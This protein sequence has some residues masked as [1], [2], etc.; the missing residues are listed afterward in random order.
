VLGS[1]IQIGS[2]NTLT[3]SVAIDLLD[4][5][6]LT[7]GTDGDIAIVERSAVLNANTSL[8]SVLIG[9]PVAQAL[10][11]DSLIISNVTA[12][13]DMAFYGNLGGHSQQFLFY[14]TSAST[15][16]L[17][18]GS[19][20]Q[21]SLALTG[22]SFD[23]TAFTNTAAANVFRTQVK[24]TNAVTLTTGTVPI[25]ATLALAEPNI[26]IG[27]GAA[28]IAA[29]FYIADAPTEGS[30]NY[31]SYTASGITFFAG[32]IQNVVTPAVTAAG[33]TLN[34][35]PTAT[36]LTAA[37]GAAFTATGKR[38]VL[39]AITP[40]ANGSGITMTGIS[41]S[42]GAIANVV[43]SETITIT[44]LNITGAAGAA[45][46]TGV[47]T[48]K[49][50]NITNPNQAANSATNA[51][52]GLNITGGAVAGSGSAYQ[53]G[54]VI[55]MAASS[56][57]GLLVTTGQSSFS[58]GVRTIL[59]TSATTANN[60]NVNAVVAGGGLTA[61][62]GKSFT[63]IV[64]YIYLPAITPVANGA[65]ITLTGL[66]M[67]AG[68]ISSVADSENITVKQIIIT[69]GAGGAAETGIYAFTG[70]DIT[71]PAQAANA[72]VNAG[73]GVKITGGATAGA[74]TAYQRGIDITMAA[75]T[76][77]AM[78][79]VSGIIDTAST[80]QFN[81][82]VDSAAVTDMV[83]LGAYEISAGHRTL[84]ISSEEPVATEVTPL[85]NDR[86][87]QVRIDGATYKIM[88]KA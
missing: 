43:D 88:L 61:A 14:D 4:D 21:L 20:V 10:A 81:T 18:N 6:L 44:Q 85:V 25:L 58:N 83:S 9:T 74:A 57:I 87:L 84:A 79:I 47:Y 63:G 40:A 86:S 33:Q 51:A 54:V 12:S 30:A 76:D 66:N 38:L 42:Q 28:T 7:L 65:G 11:A 71:T 2:P 53:R 55:T 19:T 45:L 60:Q 5:I 1:S 52:I 17:G 62:N 3:S 67:S 77:V 35:A 73:I 34:A 39:P 23:L 78:N 15:L 27:T 50:I 46:E 49:G 16:S 59:L 36:T 32:G 72:A 26:T 75:A 56:D 82:S 31:A 29:T 68:A 70:I 64:Q 37:N 41:L 13:G 69:G 22:A 24:T 80:I 48:W 8:T